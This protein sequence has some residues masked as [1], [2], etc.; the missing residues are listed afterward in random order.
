MRIKTV[1]L[2]VPGTCQGISICVDGGG[3]WRLPVEERTAR[4]KF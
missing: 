1:L 4:T 3:N 2:R